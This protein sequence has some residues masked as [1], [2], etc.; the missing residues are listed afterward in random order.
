MKTKLPL[1]MST[2]MILNLI[3]LSSC[4]KMR[5]VANSPITV[6]T[7]YNTCASP[8]QSQV[9]LEQPGYY[10]FEIISGSKRLQDLNLFENANFGGSDLGVATSIHM[11]N[12]FVGNNYTVGDPEVYPLTSFSGQRTY[13][14]A[15][16]G[17][18]AAWVD[19]DFNDAHLHP[20]NK[21]FMVKIDSTDGGGI[22][23]LP[24]W[25]K[26]R[27]FLTDPRLV[28]RSFSWPQNSAHWSCE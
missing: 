13:F 25:L 16:D 5:K 7:P 21:Y 19:V 9:T 2:L 27:G 22:V 15:I 28:E 12:D 18:D 10:F 11:F 6:P 1:L 4:S 17:A 20:L 14:Y 8:K 3:A 24:T 23:T 26:Y